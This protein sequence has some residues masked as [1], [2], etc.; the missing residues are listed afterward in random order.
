M[1]GCANVS[2]SNQVMGTLNTPLQTSYGRSRIV[3]RGSATLVAPL[4][5]K[6]TVEEREGTLVAAPLEVMWG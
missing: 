1:L 3:I 2:I 5:V 4:E 6:N